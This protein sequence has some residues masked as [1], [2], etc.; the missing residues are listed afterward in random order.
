MWCS[1]GVRNL[2]RLSVKSGVQMNL[3]STRIIGIF[4]VILLSACSKPFVHNSAI[5]KIHAPIKALYAREVP[6]LVD[7][8]HAHFFQDTN[9]I[10]LLQSNG[11]ENKPYPIGPKGYQY[12]KSATNLTLHAYA[13]IG[14]DDPNKCK[15]KLHSNAGGGPILSHIKQ[16]IRTMGYLPVGQE[17]YGTSNVGTLALLSNGTHTIGFTGSRRSQNTMSTSTI[18]LVKR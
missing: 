7:V 17:K 12:S 2:H 4:A 16:K 11:Y 18:I 9:T 8:C 6:F 1:H 15:I 14:L 3:F 10:T 13:A 5:Q